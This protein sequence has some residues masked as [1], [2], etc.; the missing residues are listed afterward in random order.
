MMP[1]AFLTDGELVGVAG[2]G[3][4]GKVGRAKWKEFNSLSFGGIPV[5]YRAKIWAD[6]VVPLPLRVP[7][8]Y[9]DL[10]SNGVDNPSIVASDPD[11]HYF[12]P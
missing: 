10:V 3:N 6:V 5:A 4:K 7:G 12:V 1:E 8:Y 11:G 2:L 9:D